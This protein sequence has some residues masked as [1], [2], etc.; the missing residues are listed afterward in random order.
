MSLLF[1]PIFLRRTHVLLR[2]RFKTGTDF[3]SLGPV[4]KPK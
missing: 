1:A 3:C 2:I 4:P